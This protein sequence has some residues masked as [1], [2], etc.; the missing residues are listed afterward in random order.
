MRRLL[1]FIAGL[2]VVGVA[3]AGMSGVSRSFPT[4]E[5]SEGAS[6]L[7]MEE[8]PLQVEMQPLLRRSATAIE[9]APLSTRRGFIDRDYV[10]FPGIENNPPYVVGPAGPQNPMGKGGPKNV[11]PAPGAGVLGAIGLIALAWV[12]RETR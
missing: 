6:I 10:P 11:L 5:V 8:R 12:R 7:S 3:H 1:G 9:F 4:I 2:G